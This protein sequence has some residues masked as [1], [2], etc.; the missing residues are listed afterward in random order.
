MI[1]KLWCAKSEVHLNVL[2]SGS[3]WFEHGIGPLTQGKSARVFEYLRELL[4][5]LPSL[6]EVSVLSK[7]PLNEEFI[8]LFRTCPLLLQQPP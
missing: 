4:P 3:V 8:A 5:T 6:C 7:L 1:Y 2:L